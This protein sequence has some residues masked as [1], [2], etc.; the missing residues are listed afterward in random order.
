MLYAK[1]VFPLALP[2]VP[3][4]LPDEVHDP[5]PKVVPHL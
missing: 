5:L 3:S 1:A 2:V 4:P